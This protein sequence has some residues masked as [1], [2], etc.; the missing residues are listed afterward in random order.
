MELYC[1]RMS[2]IAG[3][4][5]LDGQPAEPHV[6]SLMSSALAPRGRDGEGRRTVGA[7]ALCCQHLWVT[8]EEIGERQPLTGRRDET[9]VMDGRIDNRNELLG[10]MKLP[11]TTSDAAC[12]L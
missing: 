8:A 10:Q 6:L 12:A 3:L 2:G 1:R 9:L 5:N 4:W 7:A 11:A